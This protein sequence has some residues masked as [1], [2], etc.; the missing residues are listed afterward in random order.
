MKLPNFTCLQSISFLSCLKHFPHDSV[1]QLLFCVP[2]PPWFSGT[3]LHSFSSL[4]LLRQTLERVALS[5]LNLINGTTRQQERGNVAREEKR[6]GQFTLRRL[7]VPAASSFL[8]WQ[9]NMSHAS[10]H[11]VLLFQPLGWMSTMLS[12]ACWFTAQKCSQKNACP[13]VIDR[14]QYCN[15]ISTAKH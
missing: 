8:G 7:T 9:T 12:S 2:L 1:I 10:K 6:Q 11:S 13:R 5:R 4:S 3:S 15:S 14:V